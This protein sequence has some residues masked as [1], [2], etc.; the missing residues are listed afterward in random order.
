M[1]LAPLTC[2]TCGAPLSPDAAGRVFT[3]SFCGASARAE[4]RLV[5]AARFRAALAGLD[6]GARAR[7][8]VASVAGVPYR[9][10]GRVAR[11]QSSDVFL[12]ERARRLT[13]LVL[14]KVL[15]AP[16]D[17]DL[18]E[19]EWQALAALRASEAAGTA[20]FAR[21]LPQPVARGVLQA[22]GVAPRPTL[23][24]RHQS[25]FVHTFDDVVA[26]HPGGLDPR[27]TVW[28][29][30]RLLELLGWV[31][32]SGWAH[33]ALLPEHLLV[34]ARDH[35]VLVVGWSCAER[36]GGGRLRAL[37]PERAAFYPPDL[38]RGAPPSAASD[39]AM[40]ARCVAHA[41]FGGELRLPP[42]LPAPLAALLRPYVEGGRAPTDDAWRLEKLVAAAAREAFGPPTYVRLPMPG[43]R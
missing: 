14:L 12:A 3:C 35:G 38:G 39:L 19:R 37:A 43:W 13:E 9:V 21:R 31:H 23:V 5:Q 2:P 8:D 40:A 42:S 7:D 6:E 33:G 4:R 11:G 28:L 1:T 27:H 25:G 18:L 29:F 10:L 15:R 26:A 34:H 32:Q 22:P 16:D 36:L 41:A 20:Q 24:L 30:R 17:A